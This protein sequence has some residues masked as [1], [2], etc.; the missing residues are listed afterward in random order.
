M[1]YIS[2]DII[3]D[4]GS[5]ELET[6]E[7]MFFINRNVSRDCDSIYRITNND[8]VLISDVNLINNINLCL[9]DNGLIQQH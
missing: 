1:K 9:S 4:G 2:H 6:D 5:I 8:R 7:G 3:R